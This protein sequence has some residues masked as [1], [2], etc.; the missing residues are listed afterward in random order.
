MVDVIRRMRDQDKSE[1]TMNSGNEAGA[2]GTWSE[3]RRLFVGDFMSYGSLYTED[4][5]VWM[6]SSFVLCYRPIESMPL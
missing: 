5:K 6:S 4:I 3:S 1:S 2:D